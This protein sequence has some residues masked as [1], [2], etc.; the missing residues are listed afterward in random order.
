MTTNPPKPIRFGRV[1]FAIVVTLTALETYAYVSL[2]LC[3]QSAMKGRTKSG[4]Y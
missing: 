3:T 1:F 2:S 4:N